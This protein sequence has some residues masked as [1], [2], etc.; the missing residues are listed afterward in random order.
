MR[1]GDSL[2]VEAIFDNSA[3]NPNNLYSPPLDIYLG[4]ET[5]DEMA[6][7]PF[8]NGQNGAWHRIWGVCVG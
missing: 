8:A 7:A 2:H 1:K 6:M 5:A 3:T 4:E